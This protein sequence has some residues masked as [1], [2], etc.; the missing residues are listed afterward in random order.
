MIERKQIKMIRL[1]DFAEQTGLSISTCYRMIKEGRLK[2]HQ[3]KKKGAI[4]VDEIDY[5]K[6]ELSSTRNINIDKNLSPEDMYRFILKALKVVVDDQLQQEHIDYNAASKN[7][8]TLFD[9][10]T[11]LVKNEFYEDDDE[12]E[13]KES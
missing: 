6:K 3:D 2:K 9:V 5:F 8:K 13:E 10:Q 4:F 12:E 11:F 7:L 1:R